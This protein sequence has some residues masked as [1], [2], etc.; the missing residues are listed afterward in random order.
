MRGEETQIFGALADERGARQV[1]VLP[2]THSKWAIVGPAAIE[3][4]A[5]FMTGELYAV[6]R[7]HSILGRLA[8]AGS[9]AGGASRA[10]CAQPARRTRR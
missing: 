4:F 10:A 7:E 1:V 9:D 5:T 8:A 6:L 3:A 2:G